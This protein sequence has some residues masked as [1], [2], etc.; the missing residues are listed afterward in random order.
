MDKVVWSF[1]LLFTVLTH[2]K[3]QSGEKSPDYPLDI[4]FDI[5]LITSESALQPNVAWYP[6]VVP[7]AA[8][9]FYFSKPKFG[10][11]YR[12]E[13]WYRLNR[14]RIEYATVFQGTTRRPRTFWERTSIEIYKSFTIPKSGFDFDVGIGRSRVFPSWFENVSI[15]YP[16]FVSYKVHWFTLEL[17]VSYRPE[18]FRGRNTDIGVINLAAYYTFPNKKN[19]F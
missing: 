8:V 16:V 9:G 2:T 18:K 6:D 14:Y 13:L 19:G 11:R 10:I 15:E 1:F 7:L 5:G 4:R 12:K 17:R 3:G